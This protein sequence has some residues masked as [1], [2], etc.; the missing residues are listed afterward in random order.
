[1]KLELKPFQIGKRRELHDELTAA[2]E[3]FSRRGKHQAIVF[4][5]PTGSG[6]TITI[7]GLLED[8][9]NGTEDF[10]AR[11]QMRFLWISDSPELNAQSRNKLL[12]A[13]DAP[14]EVGDF[15]LVKSEQFKEEVLQPGK[16]YFINTQLLGKDKLLTATRGDKDGVTFW[17]TV[18][19]TV[20]DHG[21]DL[22]LIIDE[23]HKG[24]GISARERTKGLS[25]VRKFIQG[26]TEDGLPPVPLVL[27]MSATTQR[28]D[29]F[30]S[31]AQ[32]ERTVRKVT[33][34]AEEVR[35]S[36]LLKDQMVVMVP[37]TKVNTDM[38]L[39]ELAARRWK[40]FEK[41]WDNY[42]RKEGEPFIRP[43]LV[44]QVMDGEP[45]RNV[46]SKTPLDE[47][48]E[49][50][51]RT[52]G[53]FGKGAIVHCFDAPGDLIFGG[54]NVRRIDASRIQ[55]D[56]SARVVLFKTALSTGWDCP[57]AE[58]MMSFRK[59]IDHTLIAQLVG[60]MI[61]TP[62]ARRISTYEMLNTVELYLPHY[63][64][65][66]LEKILEELRN[67]DAE[68]RPATDVTTEQPKSYGRNPAFAKAFDVLKE[69]KTAVFSNP[70]QLSSVRRLLR[71]GFFLTGDKLDED[72]YE[73]ERDDLVKILLRHREA[74]W[75]DKEDWA[76]V[77]RETGEVELQQFIIGL[78]KMELPEAAV[79]VR[80]ELA[81]ENVEGLFREAQRRVGPGTD[82]HMAFWK[83]AEKR[84]DPLLAKL[85]LYALSGD[86]AVLKELNEHAEMRFAAL[87]STYRRKI[88]DDLKTKRRGEY[89]KLQQAGRDFTYFEWE[90][91]E[92][93]IERPGGD[94]FEQH[95]YCD[96]AGKYQTRLNGWEKAV[97]S[98]WMKRS[99]FVG[100]LRNPPSKE[101]SFCV[102]YEHG[103]CKRAFPDLIVVR[104]E[105]KELVVDVLEP[106]RTNEDDTFAKAKGLADFAETHGS[107]F[108]R[109]MMLKVDGVGEKA[110][111]LGFDVNDPSTRKKALKLRNNEE[112]QG[113]FQTMS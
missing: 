33:I 93:I 1:M 11:P 58:V 34:R 45:A 48:V 76:S 30:L 18:A 105:G 54:E 78:G 113:L 40:D 77:I 83:Q 84:T 92:E 96:E 60:R 7:A 97:L 63:D 3:E 111:V 31:E 74:R 37:E 53:T 82:M 66:N 104:R 52:V 112:V 69:L 42:S 29:A 9:L 38:T 20:R 106:H 70:M 49:V 23:A 2:T 94:F 4:S 26:S 99:D 101:R 51:R 56:E 36:G 71:M 57:R 86:A 59:A 95:L 102:P 80:A 91:P 65:A 75:K 10:P 27:G 85:E 19:N 103:G 8:L 55:D 64:R 88:R 72:A 108:G 90:L 28:F 6:K 25:I 21:E 89:R 39:L 47:V 109:L 79:K 43:V 46:L 24:M 15:E 68:D 62:L 110:L 44:V 12:N 67:P 107:S 73:R 5:S 98:L 17:Q 14:S 100:W 22:L 50:L 35:S 13:C 87:E 81:P 41:T 61:R 32:Q 16:V